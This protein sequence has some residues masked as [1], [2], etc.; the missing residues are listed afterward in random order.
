MITSPE[1]SPVGG[2]SHPTGGDSETLLSV[3]IRYTPPAGES[4]T[5]GVINLIG[6]RHGG[7]FTASDQKLLSA[8]ASQVGAALENNR[9]I[10]ESLAAERVSAE[11]ALA[12]DLQMKLLPA[13][14][15]FD[16]ADVAARVKPA[17]SVG[18]DFYHLFKLPSGRV[19]VMI[20]DVSSHGLPAA[21]IMALSMS[22]ASIYA[23][24]FG[25]PGKVLRHMDDALRGELAST[26]MYLTLFYGVIDPV[27]QHLVYSNA[28]HPHAFVVHPD[29]TRT[30]L[31]ATDP[32]V[33]FAS[34]DS[35]HEEE[36]PWT[37]PGDI[38]V[39][40]TDGLSDPL[41]ADGTGE[42]GEEVVLKEVASRRGERA[43]DIVNALFELSGVGDPSIPSDDRT[44]IILRP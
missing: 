40:F 42:Y 27:A 31:G 44:A 36:V 6:R 24:E 35:Y 23:S 7:R 1:G 38:L 3:P 12:H 17:E 37:A 21:L 39:L 9:L 8:I 29:G 20:G 16:G 26:E 4:R 19:G 33:G 11:M 10:Q 41:S 22:A 13:V 28:G 32:P 34:E 15:S 18:G 2:A 43:K 25:N 14:E 5:V 30:R